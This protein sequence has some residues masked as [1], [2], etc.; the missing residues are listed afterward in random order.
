MDEALD[1]CWIS[2]TGIERESEIEPRGGIAAP[3]IAPNIF[4]C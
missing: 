2:P 3:K 4:G 1:G